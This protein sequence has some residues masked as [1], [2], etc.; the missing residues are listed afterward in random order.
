MFFLPDLVDL[1]LFYL[2]NINLLCYRQ[3][4][5]LRHMSVLQPES[6]KSMLCQWSQY[7]IAGHDLKVE[8]QWVWKQRCERE[9]RE[10]PQMCPFPQHIYEAQFYIHWPLDPQS[11]FSQARPELYL[12]HHSALDQGSSTAPHHITT[13]RTSLDLCSHRILDNKNCPRISWP[14]LISCIRISRGKH[15]TLSPWD[16]VLCGYVP[17]LL[18]LFFVLFFSAVGAFVSD[19]LHSIAVWFS[20]P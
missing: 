3:K 5:Y 11:G 8:R 14:K 20:R 2:S 10:F 17:G 12:W 19:M 4:W 16:D 18:S 6:S 1:S 15:K 13:K 9:E 7:S